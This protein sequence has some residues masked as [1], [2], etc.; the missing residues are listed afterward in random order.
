MN[1]ISRRPYKAVSL[2]SL[3]ALAGCATA[4]PQP[5]P[6]Q[7]ATSRLTNAAV[8]RYGAHALVTGGAGVVFDKT[9]SPDAYLDTNAHSRYVVTG[10]PYTITVELATV[11]PVETIALAQSDYAKEAAPKDIEIT[12]DDGQ[13]IQKTLELARPVKQRGRTKVA[14]QEI[15]VG[16][17][18]KSFQITVLSN[19]DG[20]VKWGGLADIA[21]WTNVDLNEKFRPPGYDASAPTFINAAAPA[22]ASAPKVTMPPPAAPGEHPRLLFTPQE[23]ADFKAQLPQSEKGQQTL[24]NFL[25]MADLD[26]GLS[27]KFPSVEETVAN[28][29]DKTHNGLAHRVS[30]LGLAYGLT[31]DE[32]YVAPARQI[33]LGYAQ[34]YADY[35]RHGGRNRNDS[36]KIMFQRLSEAMWLI[37]LLEGYDYLYNDPA[38]SDADKKQIEDGLIRPAIE[39][40]RR[41]NP[42][43]E[44][45]ALTKKNADWRE[46]TPAPATKGNYPNWLNFYNT[47]TMMS[48]V[49]IGDKDMMDLAA[50][51]MRK[52]VAN[53]IGDDGMWGEGAIGYQLFA[54]SVMS[55]GFEAAA[56]NGYDIWNSSNGRFKNLFDSPLRYAYPDG[57]LPGINDSSRARLGTWQSMVYDYGYLRYADPNYAFT[58]NA[59]PRQL[60]TSEGI[61]EPTRFYAPLP[62][63]AQVKMGSTLFESLGYAIMR[64]ATKYALIDYGPHG[65]TH[66]HY[67]KLNLILFFSAP[68]GKGD[69]M[70]GEPVFHFYDN[71]LHGEWTTQSVAH[72]TMT[73]DEKSQIAGEGQLLVYEPGAGVQLMRAQSVSSYPGT[74]LDRTVLTMPD[75]VIDLFSAR[76]SL[77]HTFDRTLR[78][79]G[80]MAG[81]AAPADAKPL[82][83]SDGYQHIMVAAQGSAADGWSGTWNTK[84]GNFV[85]TLAPAPG[86]QIITGTGP[87]NEQM[88]LARQSGKS[89]DFATV[90]AL[91]GWKNPVQSA[92]WIATGD[93]AENGVSVFEMKQS[94]GTITRVMV[95]HNAG[96]WQAA[97]WKSDARVLYVREKAGATQILLGGGSFAQNGALQLRQN[98]AGNYRAQQKDGKLEMVSQWA[99][100]K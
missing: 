29:A 89:A 54:M 68:D 61:Y 52:A 48:G 86:Q 92:R 90:Y 55:P 100:Q 66:G 97:G 10:A 15:P 71:P 65:G 51:D 69:E 3:L 28:K 91:D 78:Y 84:A 20:T 36:S 24:A 39:E 2:F 76:S 47:A 80:P 25:K 72:N 70:G 75:A 96:Q 13:K 37:P 98:V 67:D 56:R 62:E 12:F 81:F 73:V 18:I 5:Q 31:G 87:D 88:A 79:N 27:I 58:I 42:A 14:W 74:L 30:A 22:V 41:Q 44:A 82:G 95:A 94:D 53:G 50:A 7:A 93:A 38:F 9:T 64:D 83:Q 85:A 32:K 19:Y 4:Q 6:Q 57:T 63:P 16:R 77:E 8:A 34:R 35:P 59:S 21:V 1:F 60:H 99:P 45:A 26:A 23:L 49:L 43:S 11:I 17:A 33:L 40:I 46:Q